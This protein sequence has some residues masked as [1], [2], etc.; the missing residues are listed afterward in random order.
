MNGSTY[1]MRRHETVLRRLGS[2]GLCTAV[3]LAGWTEAAAQ[4]KPGRW[5]VVITD[6]TELKA[7][8]EARGKAAVG[9]ILVVGEVSGDWLWVPARR[10]YVHR[11]DVVTFEE[12]I[13][14]FTAVIRREPT[15]RNYL[16]RGLALAKQGALDITR[17]ELRERALADFSAAIE[18]DPKLAAAYYW[19]GE[20]KKFRGAPDKAIE[21]YAA[22]MRIDPKNPQ[23][24]LGRG[25][26][27]HALEELDGALED[28]REAAWLDPKN[29][30]T[31][32]LRALTWHKKGELDKAI[33]DLSVAILLDPNPA[34]LRDRGHLWRSKGRL[35]KTIA[36][37]TTALRVD[38]KFADAYNAL[39]WVHA[40]CTDS[41]YRNGKKAVEYGTKACELTDWKFPPFLDSLAA[42]YAETGDFAKAVAMQQN[43]R[44]LVPEAD[45]AHFD[46]RLKL[47][48][49]GGVYRDPSRDE[50][51][52]KKDQRRDDSKSEKKNY[53][54]M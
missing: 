11:K 31:Y 25:Q 33:D 1:N 8:S 18:L 41:K 47:Y 5:I 36:D 27:R 17:K 26:A 10:G 16:N 29:P 15:A 28:F 3:L 19:R 35:D 48:Q 6:G 20:L 51:P 38:D 39:A 22:A 7:G 2:A 24:Y 12:S 9:D 14:H 4:I 32:A 23:P 37:W 45:K 40:T 49:S 43:A 34:L 46:E 42:A 13:D 52:D 54:I 50:T 30:Q 21:D 44:D 53:F